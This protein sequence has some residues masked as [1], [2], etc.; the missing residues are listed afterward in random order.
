MRACAPHP[1]SAAG[2]RCWLAWLLTACHALSGAAQLQP[3][4]AWHYR[5][6]QHEQSPEDRQIYSETEQ[7]ARQNQRGLWQGN[8]PPEPPWDYRV[9]IKAE[10][11][12]SKP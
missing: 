1:S 9:R 2:A 6:Y 3:G 11:P 7:L 8:T 12:T 5:Q 10:R 4:W